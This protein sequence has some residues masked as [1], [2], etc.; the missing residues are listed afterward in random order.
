[1]DP[2]DMSEHSWPSQDDAPAADQDQPRLLRHSSRT[3]EQHPVPTWSECRDMHRAHTTAEAAKA[4]AEARRCLLRILELTPP[5]EAQAYTQQALLP[6]QPEE[7]CPNAGP[8][9]SS[10]QQ[11]LTT[12][13]T[14]PP[15][16]NPHQTS[17]H[18]LNLQMDLLAATE[19]TGA[20]NH[21]PD[22]VADLRQA[23]T[24]V[25]EG[26]HL[27]FGR[28][29]AR[30]EAA[31]TAEELLHHLLQELQECQSLPEHFYDNLDRVVHYCEEASEAHGEAWGVPN[32]EAVNLERVAGLNSAAAKRR[33]HQ[34]DVVARAGG[35][36]S[37]PDLP[38]QQ[39]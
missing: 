37:Q 2:G 25:K 13:A 19:A 6:F 10:S 30:E 14:E 24:L 39:D 26:T 11:P 17:A 1:M 8:T 16:P 5:G 35:E 33:R 29:K 23:E 21:V 4:M 7:A 20:G 22:V 27:F 38:P 9:S 3:R 34:A 18:L 28:N 36:P 32:E 31:V 15:P 12:D